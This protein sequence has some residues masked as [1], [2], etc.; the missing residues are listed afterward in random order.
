MNEKLESKKAALRKSGKHGV[1]RYYCCG[2]ILLD[3]VR[4][5]FTYTA[6]YVL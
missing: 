2:G 5:E 6:G 4:S 1:Y 3:S